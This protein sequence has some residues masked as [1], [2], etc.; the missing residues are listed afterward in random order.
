MSKIRVF[1]QTEIVIQDKGIIH[2]AECSDG[3][4]DISISETDKNNLRVGIPG[5]GGITFT[6]WNDLKR[7]MLV[8][9]KME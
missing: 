2:I 8:D 3:S 1:E 5:E 7:A 9:L 4:F 6:Y